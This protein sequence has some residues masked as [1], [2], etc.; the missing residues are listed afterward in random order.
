MSSAFLLTEFKDEEHFETLVF[1][2]REKALRYIT[3]NYSNHT[4]YAEDSKEDVSF[5]SSFTTDT[6]LLLEKVKCLG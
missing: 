6:K 3:A 5:W 1:L 2:S 4:K